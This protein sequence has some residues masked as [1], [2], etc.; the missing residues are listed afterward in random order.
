MGSFSLLI[1][2][3]KDQ[4]LIL[5]ED[6]VRKRELEKTSRITK[7]E[8]DRDQRKVNKQLLA[9]ELPLRSSLA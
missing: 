5:V 1:K 3:L 2:S 7:E 9:K 6:Q 8:A 4:L